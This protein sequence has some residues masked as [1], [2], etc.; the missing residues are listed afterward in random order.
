MDIAEEASNMKRKKAVPAPILAAQVDVSDSDSEI[1]DAHGKGIQ[2][3]KETAE[4]SIYIQS[5]YVT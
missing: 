1:G 5:W 2:L 3:L 4:V